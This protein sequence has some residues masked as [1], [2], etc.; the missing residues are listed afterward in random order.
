MYSE[1][2][3]SSAPTMAERHSRDVDYYETHYQELLALYPDQWIAILDQKV[4]AVSNDAFELSAQL[5]KRG[6]PPNRVLRRHMTQESEL[7]ILTHL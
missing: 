3:M 6:V 7:L 4:V 2:Q 5:K 1:G